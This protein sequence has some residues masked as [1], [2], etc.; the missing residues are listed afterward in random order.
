MDVY[1]IVYKCTDN[2]EEESCFLTLGLETAKEYCR[3]KFVPPP[4]FEN[5]PGYYFYEPHPE[6]ESWLYNSLYDK[7]R[8]V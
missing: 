7:A 1:L 8:N 3:T 4:G 5:R 2:N 6:A